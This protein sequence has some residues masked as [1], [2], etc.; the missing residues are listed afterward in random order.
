MKG[1]AGQ[2][3]VK[4]ISLVEPMPPGDVK[5]AKDLVSKDMNIPEMTRSV[6][7]IY[8]IYTT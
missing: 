2:V 8:N 3:Q 5:R 7:C 6:L 1:A 4:H